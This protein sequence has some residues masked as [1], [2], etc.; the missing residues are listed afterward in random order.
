MQREYAERRIWQCGQRH[1]HVVHR[2]EQIGP[3]DAN[4]A[5]NND[6][7][8]TTNGKLKVRSQLLDE[9]DGTSKEAFRIYKSQ[10]SWAGKRVM[11]K[12]SKGR[13]KRLNHTR[14]EWE[15]AY[16]HQRRIHDEVR[17]LTEAAEAA[18]NRVS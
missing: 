7:L 8:Y 2:L 10:T 13:T 12:L 1:N 5:Q 16:A 3:V 14:T 6:F 9:L 4:I 15:H 17:Q 18:S 11:I